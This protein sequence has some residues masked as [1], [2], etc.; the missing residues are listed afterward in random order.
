MKEVGEDIISNPTIA[1]ELGIAPS[2]IPK[3]KAK[4]TKIASDVEAYAESIVSD[5]EFSSEVK[6][7]KNAIPTSVFKA[8]ESDPIGFVADLVTASSAPSWVSAI[9]TGAQ[10]YF[11]SIA[12]HV[13]NVVA[14]DVEGS[15]PPTE[16]P[17]PRPTGH[18]SSSSKP[19]P[20]G[21]HNPGVKPYPTDA[22][23]CTGRGFYSTGA[24]PSTGFPRPTGTGF[25]TGTPGPVG[26]GRPNPPTQ[27][28]LTFAGAA[29]PSFKSTTSG[30]AVALLAALAALVL[31]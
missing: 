20:P 29:P 17:H 4:L 13:I 30:A 31:M 12:E 14:D 23:S 26:S 24:F 8:A 27:S 19:Y 15:D 5:P 10:D 9:P 1:S 2:E 28:P 18:P 11:V 25:V 7:A 21:I 6:I 3:I 22:C 16:R